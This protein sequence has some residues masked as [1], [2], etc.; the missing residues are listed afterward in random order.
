MGIGAVSHTI[1]I[2]KHEIET[3][4]DWRN[5]MNKKEKEMI[6]ALTICHPIDVQLELMKAYQK[7]AKPKIIRKKHAKN[8][9]WGSFS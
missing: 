8:K 9:N 2:A 7:R 1:P 6:D 3:K 5:E 4:K